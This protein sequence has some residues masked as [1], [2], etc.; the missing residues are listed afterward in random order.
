MTTPRKGRKKAKKGPATWIDHDSEWQGLMWV[1]TAVRTPAG[2]VVYV[3]CEA[4]GSVRAL[5]AGYPV[6]YVP[7]GTPLL[8]LVKQRF[9]LDRVKAVNYFSAKDPEHLFGWSAWREAIERKKVWQRRNLGG[10]VGQDH[11]KDL[12]GWNHE[13]LK[14]FARSMGLSMADK[15]LFKDDKDRMWDAFLER[16]V[17]FVRYAVGDVDILTELRTRFVDMAAGI[18]RDVL[19]MKDPMTADTIPMTT[20]AWVAATFERWLHE[21]TGDWED[22]LKWCLRKLGVLDDAQ[23]HYERNRA[24]YQ[25]VL[26]RYQGVTA[27]DLKAALTFQWDGDLLRFMDANHWFRPFRY[28]ALDAGGIKWFAG[29]SDTET[30]IFNALV[31]GGRCVNEWAHQYRC[32]AGLDIDVCSC[33][34]S[35]LRQQTYPVGL[36]TVWTYATNE[37]APTLGEWLDANEVEL[38][39]GLWQCVVSGQLAFDQ[40]VIFNRVC[41]PED[42]RR[43]VRSRY[44]DEDDDD[45]K[46]ESPLLRNEIV[47]GILTHDLLAILRAAATDR[48]WKQLKQLKVVTAAA[49]LKKDRLEEVEGWCQAVISDDGRLA[50][51]K[52]GKVVKD[53]RTKAWLAVA[54][55]H[56]IGPLITERQRLKARKK[57]ATLSPEEIARCTG[58]DSMFK[59]LVNT[60]FGDV[61]SRHFRVGNVVV[62]NNITA[63][64]R[65]GVWMLAKALGLRQSITDGGFYTPDRVCVWKGPRPGLHTL[66]NMNDWQDRKNQRRGFAPL[67]GVDWAA[68]LTAGAG[69]LTEA[70]QAAYWKGRLPDPDA[71][72]LEHVRAFWAPYGLEFP[73]ALVEH[74]WEN[75]FTAAAW[76]NKGDYALRRAVPLKDEDGVVP[77]KY[78]VRGKDKPTKEGIKPHPTYALFD[79]I[80][81]GRDDFPRDLTYTKGGLVTINEYRQYQRQNRTAEWK[82]LR[83]GDPKPMP[84]QTA[85]YNNKHMPAADLKAH[86]RRSK[87]RNRRTKDGRPMPLF[88]K[89]GAA[90]IQLVHERMRRDDLR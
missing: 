46:A 11:V 43:A 76:W 3:N 12:Y 48:E 21:R 15:D 28:T 61:C 9:G 85:V 50:S 54:L 75:T 66:A 37:K 57:D 20:G 33:Y 17:A 67:G 41:D 10:R 78:A 71:L 79:A 22:T 82:A 90:G 19:H 70:E 83:P 88:E 6:E 5:L 40:D 24:A 29:R 60:L 38:L 47:N 27:R 63:R 8:P 23:K 26:G 68:L 35:N 55:E 51:G 32:G 69:P 84:V 81:D 74:K 2:T 86:R 39:P 44:T 25:A 42:I 64:A 14:R 73:F 36:P 77:V 56:F 80:L 34:G 1:C 49:Y 87:A 72:A 30:A 62:A 89:Y 59:L 4:P 7:Q 58:L 52:E 45:V 16:P 18:Q 13:G 53:G 31:Q 65:A